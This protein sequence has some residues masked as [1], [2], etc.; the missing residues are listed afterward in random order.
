L[1]TFKESN[2]RKYLGSYFL[3]FAISVVANLTISGFA[4]AVLIS[5]ATL[6]LVAVALWWRGAR[7]QIVT[8]LLIM[9]L[10]VYY[11]IEYIP[12]L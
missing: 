11:A 3:Y 9:T 2:G 5:M 7:V 10:F 1:V 4:T 12:S 6:V 8:V